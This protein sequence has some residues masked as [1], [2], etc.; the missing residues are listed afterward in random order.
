MQLKRAVC[1]V[2]T[3]AMCGVLQ[4][5]PKS[6]AVADNQV[7]IAVMGQQDFHP[8]RAAPGN[9]RSLPDDLAARVIEHL[10]ASRSFVEKNNQ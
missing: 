8:D 2:L 9:V 6:L 7:R 1:A 10:E 5:A 3:M 4:A